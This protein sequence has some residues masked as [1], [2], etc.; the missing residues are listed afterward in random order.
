MAPTDPK[1]TFSDDIVPQMMATLNQVIEVAF[2]IKGS[3]PDKALYFLQ[4]RRNGNFQA[5]VKS[6]VEAKLGSLI[7]ALKSPK[8]QALLVQ[9]KEYIRENPSIQHE[10]TPPHEHRTSGEIKQARQIDLLQRVQ[11]PLNAKISEGQSLDAADLM[12]LVDLFTNTGTVTGFFENTWTE[13]LKTDRK[14]DGIDETAVQNIRSLD[15]FCL[16]APFANENAKRGFA[17]NI[18]MQRFGFILS[19]DRVRI[20]SSGIVDH[21]IKE[22]KEPELGREAFF[23]HMTGRAPAGEPATTSP[24]TTPDSPP[25]KPRS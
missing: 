17:Q 24:I 3:F 18:L 14:P 8:G 12:L 16:N 1:T 5:Q 7:A 23:R 11:A 22:I 15:A 9:L 2:P 6:E 19:N 21:L 25:N 4:N 20:S 13:E 10:L